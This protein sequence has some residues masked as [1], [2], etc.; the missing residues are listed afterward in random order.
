MISIITAIYNQKNVN[1]LFWESLNK[2]TNCKFE[3]I[4]IDNDS[5]DGS[6]E[7]FESVGAIVI[8]NKAN[9]SYPYCQNQGIKIAKYN[10][11]VFMNND[12]IVSKDWNTHIIANMEANSLDVATFCGIEHLET[13]EVTRSIKNR[14]KF[15]K[16][17]LSIFGRSKVILKLMHHLMYIN[18]ESFT[19]KRYNDFLKQTKEG[20]VGNT[21]VMRKEALDKIGLWDDR[22][23]AADF[24]LYLRVKK[25]E[26]EYQ[27]I[28]A[29]HICLDTFIHH[30]IRLTTYA[31]P[32]KFVDSANLINIE[33][34]WGD[35][36]TYFPKY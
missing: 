11:L 17:T 18:W 35:F 7:F 34:K 19:Q 6:A 31:N 10:W 28:K 12:V 36:I 2:Y 30:Y 29:V 3:L 20:I 13:K 16:N 8:R 23:Q 22:I 32:P 24:D 26:L 1:K 21:V 4:I 33:D 9:Y 15:I 25:R 14:W 27:D 5:S